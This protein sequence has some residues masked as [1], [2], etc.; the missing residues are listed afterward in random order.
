[1][2]T[3]L[4]VQNQQPPRFPEALRQSRSTTQPCKKRNR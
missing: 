4:S 2:A 1:M 3:Q